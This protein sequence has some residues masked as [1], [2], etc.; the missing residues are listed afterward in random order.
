MLRR[1]NMPYILSLKAFM[2]T[3]GVWLGGSVKVKKVEKQVSDA[4]QA[5]ADVKDRA[6]AA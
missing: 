5:T 6:S 2:T 3:V 1:Y 4:R